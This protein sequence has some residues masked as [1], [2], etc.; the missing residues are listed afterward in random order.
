MQTWSDICADLRDESQTNEKEYERAIAKVVFRWGLKWN[1]NQ[2]KQSEHIQYGSRS[3]KTDITLY[4]DDRLQTIIEVKKPNTDINNIILE[5][6]TSYMAIR[7]VKVGIF[8]GRNI[9]VF[10]KDTDGGNEPK[11]ILSVNLDGIDPNGVDFIA[12]FKEDTF[13]I[14]RIE[15]YYQEWKRKKEKEQR[16]ND[17]IEFLISSNGAETIRALLS[18]YLKSD[19]FTADD[20]EIILDKINIEISKNEITDTQIDTITNPTFQTNNAPSPHRRT[21]QRKKIKVT[22]PNG[23]TIIPTIVLDA[24]LEVIKFANPARVMQLNIFKDGENIV[25]IGGHQNPLAES[26][27][28]GD[29]YYVNTHSST[30]DKYNTIKTISDRLGL[31]LIVELV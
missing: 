13:S 21:G 3:L 14:E 20:C 18:D 15:K 9:E 29:R 10:Y 6:L 4:K 5:Q 8:I 16:V 26:K 25:S 7:D 22:F 23:N 30:Q 31:N 2:I 1:R 27:Y 17:R 12:L 28:L 24:L 19:G 11:N